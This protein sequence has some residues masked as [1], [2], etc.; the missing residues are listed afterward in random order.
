MKNNE[1]EINMVLSDRGTSLLLVFSKF[2]IYSPVVIIL[3]HYK[4]NDEATIMLHIQ[5]KL[6][7][8]TA[9]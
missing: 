3:C 2:Y 8:Q 4:R 1:N 9:C 6:K 7:V 5:T